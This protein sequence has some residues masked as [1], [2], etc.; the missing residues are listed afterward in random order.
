MTAIQLLAM[1]NMPVWLAIVTTAKAPRLLATLATTLHATLEVT[2]EYD[3]TTRIE[4]A[5]TVAM[6]VVPAATFK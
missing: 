6:M 1:A 4:L 2:L 3:L 5:T